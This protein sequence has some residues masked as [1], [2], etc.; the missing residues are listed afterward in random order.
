MNNSQYHRPKRSVWRE[1]Q[2][3]KVSTAL[4]VMNCGP[5]RCLTHDLP[6]YPVHYDALSPITGI[7]VIYF[8][9]LTA[10]QLVGP[11][12]E[13]TQSQENTLCIQILVSDLKDKSWFCMNKSVFHVFVPLPAKAWNTTT[14]ITKDLWG[15][16]TL[17]AKVQ[18][19]RMGVEC[20]K[21]DKAA[22]LASKEKQLLVWSHHS[23]CRSL[24]KPLFLF[25]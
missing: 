24:N 12:H 9:T 1:I 19:D 6:Q 10:S 8:W 3:S 20:S 17:T 22:C 5:L 21:P 16:Q 2:P 15:H 7:S 23:T 25:P 13:M 4:A 14:T 18:V 11:N